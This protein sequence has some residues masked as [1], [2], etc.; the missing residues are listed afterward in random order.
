MWVNPIGVDDE[1]SST[2]SAVLIL[3]IDQGLHCA[4]I[5]SLTIAMQSVTH[6]YSVFCRKV[7]KLPVLRVI[8]GGQNICGSAISIVALQ[9]KESLHSWVKYSWSSVQPQKFPAIRTWPVNWY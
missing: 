7:I 1:C 3:C 9:V 6:A 4:C 8:F 5:V 2:A